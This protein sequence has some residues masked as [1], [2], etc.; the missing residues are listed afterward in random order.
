MFEDVFSDGVYLVEW[1]TPHVDNDEHEQKL[2]EKLDA[3]LSKLQQ[4]APTTEGS[5]V[6]LAPRS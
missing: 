1:A 6:R 4:P 5:Q 3:V 2:V